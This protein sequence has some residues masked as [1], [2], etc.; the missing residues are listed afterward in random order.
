MYMSILNGDLAHVGR[1]V[2]ERSAGIEGLVHAGVAQFVTIFSD[3]T[4]VAFQAFPVLPAASPAREG[5]R[6]DS[7]PPWADL[8]RPS[9]SVPAARA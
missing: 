5:H 2:V 8:S 9:R 3:V 6:A 1:H 7:E 4:A